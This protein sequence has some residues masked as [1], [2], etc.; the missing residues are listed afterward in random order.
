MCHGKRSLRMILALAT[1]AT[2]LACSSGSP[3]P[4]EADLAPA[5]PLGFA[6]DG[7]NGRG[8]GSGGGGGEGGGSDKALY[9]LDISGGFSG[10]LANVVLKNDTKKGLNIDVD[11]DFLIDFP[12]VTE[13]GCTFSDS[14]TT[15]AEKD[16]L[17]ALVDNNAVVGRPMVLVL[18][19]PEVTASIRIN[20]ID[21]QVSL[22]WSTRLGFCAVDY[23][24]TDIDDSTSTRNLYFSAAVPN[25]AVRL[26]S[27]NGSGDVIEA[28]CQNDDDVTVV[29]TPQ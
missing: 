21:L 27:R 16:Q 14:V 5:A 29:L 4:T 17:L 22:C 25:N 15:Q 10:S 2:C 26:L 23:Q 24:G 1:V 28:I 3:S 13:A 20:E 8:N 19:K 6:A 12:S 11:G 18:K 9:S 7:N